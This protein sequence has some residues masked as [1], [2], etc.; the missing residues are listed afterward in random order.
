MLSFNFETLNLCSHSAVPALTWPI[1]AERTKRPRIIFTREK[2][3][4][5]LTTLVSLLKADASQ[6]APYFL[7]GDGDDVADDELPARDVLLGTQSSATLE[8]EPR[9]FEAKHNRDILSMKADGARNIMPTHPLYK[10]DYLAAPFQINRE[11]AHEAYCN[12]VDALNLDFAGDKSHL[13]F[14]GKQYRGGWKGGYPGVATDDG[15][16]SLVQTRCVFPVGGGKPGTKAVPPAC[17]ESIFPN[18]YGL[19]A[20]YED[21]LELLCDK[22]EK[23]FEDFSLGQ[24]HI[25]FGYSQMAHFSYHRDSNTFDKF[26]PEI[27]AVVQLSRGKSSMRV[28]TAGHPFQYSRAGSGVFFDSDL[29]HRGERQ[30]HGTVKVAFFF[31][32]RVSKVK[33]E[34]AAGSSTDVK[35]EEEEEEEEEEEDEDESPAL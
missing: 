25:L 13:L 5:P 20:V 17:K 14:G 7:K 35:Q 12:V 29:Y 18:A 33:T 4:A 10:S 11:H 30:E 22:W 3:Q 16:D 6:L 26:K 32:E 8:E 9:E 19:Y 24:F 15:F 31:M 34:G 28:A 1:M 27:S 21:V 23:K 2:V